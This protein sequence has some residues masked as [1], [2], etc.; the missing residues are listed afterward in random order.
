MKTL[1]LT[2]LMSLQFIRFRP[3]SSNV[4]FPE[5]RVPVLFF[6]LLSNIFW[7]YTGEA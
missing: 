3:T 6:L 5:S 2:N 7:T 4:Q 1:V